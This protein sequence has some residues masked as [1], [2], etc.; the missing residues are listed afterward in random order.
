MKKLSIVVTVAL[1]VLLVSA[2]TVL[3]GPKGADR[4][5]KGKAEG[6]STVATS[7]MPT[8]A[9][10]SAGALAKFETA[11]TGGFIGSH[12]GKGTYVG[13][14]TQTWFVKDAGQCSDSVY[15]AVAS[16][17]TLTAANGDTLHAIALPESVVC[18]VSPADR[19]LTVYESTIIY[20]ID[21]GDGRFA[22]ASGTFTSKSIHTRE[23]ASSGSDDVGTWK[24]KIIY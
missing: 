2:T 24:G 21:G 12:M 19:L 14:S 8:E 16:D 7:V 10:I 11:S 4:P 9:E 23:D 20:E 3:A 6:T 22:S 13:A 5:F 18:D 15:G 1:L 17:I